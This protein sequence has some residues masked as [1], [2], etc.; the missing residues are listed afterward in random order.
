MGDHQKR[1][2]IRRF[3]IWASASSN[4]PP[5]RGWR[6]FLESSL[7]SQDPRA[8]IVSVNL[9]RRNLTKGQQAMALAMIYP[10]AERGR[11]KKDPAR[12]SPDSGGI[13]QQRLSDART[14]LH[15]SEALA[16][17]VIKGTTSL[18]TAGAS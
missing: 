11:G 12:K 13:T 15:Y 6:K 14:V 5:G 8:Y 10:E 17:D 16:K 4:R 1:Q 2:M 3:L 7:N 18:L 9:Q